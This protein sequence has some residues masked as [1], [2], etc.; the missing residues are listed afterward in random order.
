MKTII[1]SGGLGSRLGEYTENIPKPMI[2]IGEKPLLWHVMQR[3]AMFG[4]TDFSIALGYKAHVIKDY[5]LNYGTH[6]NDFSINL[7]NGEIHLLNPIKDNWNVSLCDTGSDTQT[8]GRVKRLSN[9]ING[10]RFFLT[11]GDGVANIDIDKLLKFHINHGKMITISAVHPGAR[12]GELSISGTTVNE[13]REKPQTNAGWINGGYFVV[14]PEFLD[15]I[16]NDKTVLEEGPLEKAA[17]MGQLEAYLHAGFWHCVDTKRDKVSLD[18]I[19]K[20]GSAP[21][22]KR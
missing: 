5:F 9:Q 10:E 13:F 15:L 12:F 14:E 20:S 17:S 1:L 21:W 2:P 11:Y 22:I 4:H 16:K 3:F 8:G 19:W 7:E 18:E 6:N